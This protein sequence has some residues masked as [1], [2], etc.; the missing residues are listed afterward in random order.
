MNFISECHYE[1]TIEESN[2]EAYKS[3]IGHKIYGEILETAISDK[4]VKVKV[5]SGDQTLI[6]VF[7]KI[8]D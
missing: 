8:K 2:I 5:K 4:L 6:V 3:L 7:E 1:L